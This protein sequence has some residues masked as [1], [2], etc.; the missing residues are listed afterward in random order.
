MGG[1]KINK[2]EYFLLKRVGKTISEYRLIED[3]DRI[4]VGVSG[5]KDSLSLLRLL[6]VRLNYTAIKYELLAVHIDFGYNPHQ[7]EELIKY[8]HDQG[9]QYHI[10]QR[11]CDIKP[12]EKTNCFWCSWN[13]R[14][15][16][17]EVGDRFGFK[18]IA[19]AHNKDDLVET[20]LLNLFYHGEISTMLPSLEFFNGR[21]L[22]IR[23][24]VDIEAFELKRYAEIMHLPYYEHRC[25]FQADTTKRMKM[26][27]LI[28]SLSRENP[29]IKRNILRSLKKEEI[30]YKP[31]RML[32]LK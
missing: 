21:F 32:G 13:R 1:E 10:E 20:V 25:P 24:L 31:R 9:Y 22:V 18:K 30:L 15:A 26:R 29:H 27:E 7:V 16:L 2:Y 19:L 17:F 28:F 14:K 12:G 6:R 3:N 8:F 11:K 5:G 23:P 4:M